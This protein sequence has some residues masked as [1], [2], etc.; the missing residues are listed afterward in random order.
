MVFAFG[1]RHYLRHCDN[2]TFRVLVF[3]K[4]ATRIIYIIYIIYYIYNI[5]NLYKII[6]RTFK[7]F[8]HFQGSKLKIIFKFP[9]CRIVALSHC[10]AY[11]WY[12]YG[13]NDGILLK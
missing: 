6:C 9:N 12:E 10:A 1:E 3:N 7:S 5:Y 13:L 2:A 11:W 4:F 8:N